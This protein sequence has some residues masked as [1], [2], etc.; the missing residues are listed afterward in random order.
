MCIHACTHAH[1]VYIHVDI[2]TS[3]TH[4]HTLYTHIHI[5]THCTHMHNCSCSCLSTAQYRWCD[6]PRG[7]RTAWADCHTASAHLVYWQWWCS[8]PETRGHIVISAAAC[9][10]GIVA[11]PTR[12]AFALSARSWCSSPEV[13]GLA[14]PQQRHKNGVRQVIL[15][16]GVHTES[17]PVVFSISWLI[18]I[19]QESLQT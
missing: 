5:H 19:S 3:D 2:H 14:R 1:A 6:L 8:H 13:K 16:G 11:R 17:S 15:L 10:F 12:A 9:A 7:Q 18:A 4:I